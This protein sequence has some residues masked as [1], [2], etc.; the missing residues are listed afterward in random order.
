MRVE[1]DQARRDRRALHLVLTPGRIAVGYLLAA[2]LWI[3]FSDRAAEALSRGNP[4]LLG[5]LQTVKGMFFIAGT[6]LML[7]LLMRAARRE[8]LASEARHRQMFELS[9]AACLLL[10][11]S[12]GRIMDAN[13]AAVQFYGWSREELLARRIQDINTLPP[14]RV[15][16]LIAAAQRQGG[17]YFI[18]Q[19]RTASGAIR[20]VEVHAGPVQ[21]D[22][23]PMLFS[24]IHDMTARVAAERALEESEERYRTLLGEAPDGFFVAREDGTL[25]DVNPAACAMLGYSRAELLSMRMES[26]VDPGDLERH[27]GHWPDVRDDRHVIEERVLRRKDGTLIPVEVSA[28]RRDD[29]LLQTLARDI[30][31]RRMLEEQLRQAQK[32]EAV[33]QLTGG[34]AHDLNN[35]LGVVIANADLIRHAL[36]PGQDEARG[37]LDEIRRAAHRG[38]DMIRKLLSF[39]RQSSLEMAPLDLGS[40][41]ADIMSSLRRLLPSDIAVELEGADPGL[42]VRADRGALEQILVNLATNARDAMPEGGR[43]DIT[44]SRELR[45]TDGELACVTVSDTGQGM[46]REV[47]NRVFEP[48]FTT[49]PPERGSGLG[50]AMVYGLVRQMSGAIQL[51]S[52]PG[53]GTTIQ[54]SFPSLPAAAP[55]ADAH[56]AAD[57]LPRGTEMI[58]VVEDEVSL[59]AATARIL[60]RLGYT[61][62]TAGDGDEAL[63]IFRLQHKYIKLVI[64][65]IV[66]PRRSGLALYDALRAGGS[67][68]PFLLSSGYAGRMAARTENPDGPPLLKKPWL[69]EELAIKVREMLDQAHET[70]PSEVQP[71]PP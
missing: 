55:A 19:H 6:A 35:V 71:A 45:G 7:Y 32:M 66:M 5:S 16:D 36:K 58:L 51:D 27:A 3:L 29:G 20:D 59:R 40:S 31:T 10:D 4:A 54:L 30:S 62:L 9:S 12:S 15:T 14:D 1:P 49:K 18:F 47:R 43:L 61:V 53:K 11:S 64:S 41:V 2:V 42:T 52:T 63:D 28:R 69:T 65:D 37:D 26:L 8:L 57:A 46:S 33:G 23:R 21:M 68:V 24:I 25:V 60:R 48:F 70:E 44:I 50:M 34:I 39:S 38:A 67:N 22:G 56:T 13:Q 17:E